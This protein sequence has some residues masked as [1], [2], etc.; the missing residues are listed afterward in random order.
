MSQFLCEGA[1]LLSYKTQ[2]VENKVI[3]LRGPV[4]SLEFLQALPSCRLWEPTKGPGRTAF[5]GNLFVQTSPH[6]IVA[7]VIMLIWAQVYMREGPSPLG[8]P[9]SITF[10]FLKLKKRQKL[11]LHIYYLDLM[12]DT[13]LELE[14]IS[15]TFPKKTFPGLACS[16]FSEH[17]VV[18]SHC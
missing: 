15:N 4:F 16:V 7:S 12:S 1:R 2:N 13:G 18:F 6:I 3:F 9:T 11:Y 17:C 10:D 8:S 14:N 5:C